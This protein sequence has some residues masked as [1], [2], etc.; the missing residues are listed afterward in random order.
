M[1]FQPTRLRD[2]CLVKLE[3]ARDQRGY[4]ART[5]CVE[6][7]YYPQHS[8]LFSARKGTLRGQRDP[9][10]EVKLVRC[11]HGAILV[12]II[13]IRPNSPTYRHWQG[14]ELSSGNGDQIYIPKG[15]AHGFQTLSDDVEVSYLISTPYAPASASGIRHDDPAFGIRWPLSITEISKKDLQW[16]DF[17]QWAL[18]VCAL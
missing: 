3:A 5:S 10:V 2:A 13:D 11:T 15:F 8:I 14:F 12:V 18:Q 6:D 1:K 16:P 4:F 7:V 9:H 17:A